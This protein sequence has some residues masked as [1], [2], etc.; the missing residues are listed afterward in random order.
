MSLGNAKLQ[1]CISCCLTQN[2]RSLFSIEFE[3]VVTVGEV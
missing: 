1:R 3:T 2:E